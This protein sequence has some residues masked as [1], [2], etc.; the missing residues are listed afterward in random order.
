MWWQWKAGVKRWLFIGW[1][2]WVNRVNRTQRLKKKKIVRT[3]RSVHS[4]P[5]EV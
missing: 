3:E 4:H 5:E 1:K 2:I